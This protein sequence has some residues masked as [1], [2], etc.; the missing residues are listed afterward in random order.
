MD[1]ALREAMSAYLVRYQQTAIRETGRRPLARAR[2][3]MDEA[4]VLPGCQ[5][6]GYVFW[7]PVPWGGAQ[8]PF[9]KR[10]A[11]FHQSIRDYLSVCRFLEIR[12]RLPV[13]QAKTPLR[14]LYDRVFEAS[15]NTRFFTPGLAFD[16]AALAHKAEPSMPLAYC[17]A[18]TCDDGEP[19]RILLGASDGQVCFARAD[20]G[21]PVYGR[22]TVERLLPKLRFVYEL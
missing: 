10:K 16:E 6:P 9:G 21:E 22:M 5:R 7:Q 13:T 3:P 14:F 15:A 8:P 20:G 4:L 12:F 18:T 2:T 1:T 11:L 19:L 17:M